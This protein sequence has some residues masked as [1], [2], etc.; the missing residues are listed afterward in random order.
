LGYDAKDVIMVMMSSGR[1]AVRRAAGDV[2]HGLGD[3]LDAIINT[4][5]A[6]A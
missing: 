5:G 2:G 6:V 3:A 4:S 1:S